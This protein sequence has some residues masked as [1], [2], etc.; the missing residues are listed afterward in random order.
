[1]IVI[2]CA[3][4]QGIISW[5]PAVDE[6]FHPSTLGEEWKLPASRGYCQGYYYNLRK[7]LRAAGFSLNPAGRVDK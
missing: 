4:G 5:E 7:L 6:L 1:M 3:H 2:R